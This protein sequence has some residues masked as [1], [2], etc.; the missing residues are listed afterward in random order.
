MLKALPFPNHQLRTK[1]CSILESSHRTHPQSPRWAKKT[2]CKIGL[3]FAPPPS[4]QVL[5]TLKRL[6]LATLGESGLI[7]IPRPLVCRLHNLHI[8]CFCTSTRSSFSLLDL[9]FDGVFDLLHHTCE[10]LFDLRKAALNT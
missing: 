5:D 1:S 8:W 9:A 7:G 3:F 4:F 6:R 2:L 10:V